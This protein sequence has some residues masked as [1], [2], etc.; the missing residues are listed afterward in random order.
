M[1]GASNRNREYITHLYISFTFIVISSE[2]LIQRVWWFF[3]Q[4]FSIFENK[5]EAFYLIPIRIYVFKQQK[6]TDS[7]SELSNSQ[8]LRLLR[9]HKENHRSYNILVTAILR[10]NRKIKKIAVSLRPIKHP[11]QLSIQ[12]MKPSIITLA[13]S[14]TVAYADLIGYNRLGNNVAYRRKSSSEKS[15]RTRTIF[16]KRYKNAVLNFFSKKK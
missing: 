13:L 2:L 16:E 4:G 10:K 8:F 5:T 3:I 14:S 6:R 12:R 7:F 9:P 11:T 15:F 1:T